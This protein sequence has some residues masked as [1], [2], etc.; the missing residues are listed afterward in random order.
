[1]FKRGFK[2]GD[3]VYLNPKAKFNIS[4][5][6]RYQKDYPDEIWEVLGYD[7]HFYGYSIYHPEAGN[8]HG[9]NERKLIPANELSLIR[10]ESKEF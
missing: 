1:M 3:A 4:K 6:Q 9:V 2:K 7:E 8:A 5:L 10:L